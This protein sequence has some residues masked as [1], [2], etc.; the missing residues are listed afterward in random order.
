MDRASC[1]RRNLRVLG[2]MQQITA[3]NGGFE[4]VIMPGSRSRTQPR[5]PLDVTFARRLH[6]YEAKVVQLENRAI[7]EEQ[8]LQFIRARSV[9]IQSAFL[10]HRLVPVFQPI[11]DLR[12]RTATG[13]EALSLPTRAFPTP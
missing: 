8:D 9:R 13:C 10:R 12:T 1:S 5:R 2:S 7:A 6:A 4:G 11:V 3:H